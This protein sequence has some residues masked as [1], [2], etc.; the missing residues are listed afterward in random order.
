MVRGGLGFEFLLLA[1]EG[2]A[3]VD[4]AP[5]HAHQIL[6]PRQG[7]VQRRGG[8]QTLLLCFTLFRN[9]F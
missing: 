5:P 4:E 3:L 1:A 2:G 9:D 7:R 8:L 6:Q